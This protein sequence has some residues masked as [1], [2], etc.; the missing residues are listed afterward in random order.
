MGRGCS[1]PE[2]RDGELADGWRVHLLL[3]G[4]PDR[5]SQR[6]CRRQHPEGPHDPAFQPITHASFPLCHPTVCSRSVRSLDSQQRLCA[7]RRRPTAGADVGRA[8]AGKTCYTLEKLWS[9][10]PMLSRAFTPHAGRQCPPRSEAV[11][12][13]S[14]SEAEARETEEVVEKG[15]PQRL[16]VRVKCEPWSDPER[17]TASLRGG[18]RG[19]MVGEGAAADV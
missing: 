2:R 6:Y 8:V 12:G 15:C 13:R 17:W 9:Y 10:L 11:Q 3:G 7:H 1:G 18:G 19:V 14:K 16:L 5:G 4:T